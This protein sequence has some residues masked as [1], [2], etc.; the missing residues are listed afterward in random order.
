MTKSITIDTIYYIYR[1]PYMYCYCLLRSDKKNSEKI[2][3]EQYC[4]KMGSNQD[5]K[6][7]QETILSRI[8]TNVNHHLNA[9]KIDAFDVVDSIRIDFASLQYASSIVIQDSYASLE[10]VELNSEIII[11]INIRFILQF[12]PTCNGS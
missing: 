7:T 2:T 1:C 3:E 11:C 10:L 6:F 12:F 9:W 8:F 5:E 4:I